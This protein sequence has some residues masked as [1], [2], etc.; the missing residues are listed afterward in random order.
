MFT[1]IQYGCTVGEFISLARLIEEGLFASLRSQG[2]TARTTV[3]KIKQRLDTLAIQVF[4]DGHP[5]SAASLWTA[6]NEWAI[7]S[8]SPERNAWCANVRHLSRFTWIPPR[9][10]TTMRSLRQEQKDPTFQ[11][12]MA[13]GRA[14]HD[15]PDSWDEIPRFTPRSW[16]DLRKVRKA[17]AR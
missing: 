15:L 11:D 17:W 9:R 16:K 5:M 1:L 4:E 10:A 8:H 2:C 14:G 7:E 6:M 3:E 13:R 12:Q